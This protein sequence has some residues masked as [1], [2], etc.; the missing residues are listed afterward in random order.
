MLKSIASEQFGNYTCEA[1]ND[2][3]GYC[4]KKTVEIV[5]HAFLKPETVT[6]PRNQTVVAGFDVTFNCTA[7]GHPM[8]SIIWIKNNASLTIQSDLRMKVIMI[9]LDDK[10]IHSQL[11]ITGVQ[12]EDGGKYHCLANNRAGKG[13]SAPAF[14]TIKDLD[15]QPILIVEDPR[16]RSTVVGSDVTLDCITIGRP[17]PKIKWLRNDNS[18]AV[19]SNSRASIVQVS[20][21][22]QTIHHQLVITAVR[23]EDDGKYQCVAQNSAGANTSKEAFI[24]VMDQDLHLEYKSCTE[25]KQTKLSTFQIIAIAVGVSAIV[26]VIGAILWYRRHVKAGKRTVL[27]D[28]LESPLRMSVV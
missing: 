3:L 27:L 10:H 9:T 19:E 23:K 20:I 2:Y 24:N 25:V 22:N 7:K 6:D 8:P 12:R 26:T 17:K 1:E 11:V 28:K 21:N 4:R 18:N 15:D 5:L 13:A 14:L 16:N